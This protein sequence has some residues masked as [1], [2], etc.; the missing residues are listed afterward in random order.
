MPSVG[1]EVP[2]R[3]EPISQATSSMATTLTSA[4]PVA[5]SARAGDQVMW[6]RS[7]LPR[8]VVAA[9]PTEAQTITMTT[10]ATAARVPGDRS[11][12]ALSQTTGSA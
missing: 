6:P 9:W 8:C 11:P 5:S 1:R 4:P 7:R 10:A 12:A 3:A 2:A